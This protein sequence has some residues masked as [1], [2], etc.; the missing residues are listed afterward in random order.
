MKEFCHFLKERAAGQLGCAVG[1]NFYRVGQAREVCRTCPLAGLG[2]TPL[3]EHLD[4]Y[5]YRERKQGSLATWV[6]VRCSLDEETPPG[7]RCPTCPN[8]GQLVL[9]T[10]ADAAALVVAP[11]HS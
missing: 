1:V 4:V 9:T 3:C 7:S 11:E 10:P 8:S 2:S 5:V 6:E